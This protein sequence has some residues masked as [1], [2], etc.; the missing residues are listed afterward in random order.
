MSC[1]D[2]PND[3]VLYFVERITFFVLVTLFFRSIK[4]HAPFYSRYKVYYID[5]SWLSE[6]I[7]NHCLPARSTLFEKIDYSSSCLFSKNGTVTRLWIHYHEMQILLKHLEKNLFSYVPEGEL[8]SNNFYMYL[9][10]KL[11]PGVFVGCGGGLWRSLF[12][13]HVLLWKL[14]ALS[15][16]GKVCLILRN[17]VFIDSLKEYLIDKGQEI[18]LAPMGLA[19]NVGRNVCLLLLWALR[20]LVVRAA[21]IFGQRHRNVEGSTEDHKGRLAVN[22]ITHIN[23]SKAGLHSDFAFWQQSNFPDNALLPMVSNVSSAKQKE[24]LA[25]FDECKIK[26]IGFGRY[27]KYFCLANTSALV[28]VAGLRHV[29]SYFLTGRY[30][31]KKWI[32]AERY[33]FGLVKEYWQELFRKHS[34]VTYLTWMKYSEEHCAI[35]DAMHDVGGV[36][37]LYQRSYEGNPTPE[38]RMSA[39][40]MFGFSSHSA[41]VEAASGSQ[42]KLMVITGYLGDHRFPL[43]QQE[44]DEI[45]ARLMSRGCKHIVAFFDENSS[46]D[47][48]WWNG[49]EIPRHQYSF[50]LKKLLDDPEIGLVLKP[51]NPRT[52]R[53]RL[54][55][56][57]ELLGQALQTG[58]CYLY[59][60]GAIQGAV[61]PA[62]AALSADVAVHGSVAAAT[63]G[64][65]SILAGVPTLFVD[66]EGFVMSPFYTMGGGRNV[67]RSWDELWDSLE[68]HFRDRNKNVNYGRF[69]EMLDHFDPFR[70]G[71]AAE[72]MGTFLNWIIEGYRSGL[73]KEI[74]LSNAAQRYC[75][76]WGNDKVVSVNTPMG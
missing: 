9:L 69:P 19:S 15:Y 48:R 74:V 33:R 4:I 41:E 70:D 71:R 37:A 66:D 6:L 25:Q 18:K 21:S 36:L 5:S 13:I 8:D 42:I 67:F 60:Q 45:R 40:V 16:D 53:K 3:K 29:F 23:L 46:L 68:S 64:V 31:E 55:S 56:V 38:T 17:Q 30:A 72:R 32:D 27:S 20:P 24:D 1:L 12:I 52:L 76:I 61:C 62:Q 54:G 28:G 43:V 73:T 10:R 58:R 49:H 65:E 39:D 51:K 47:S 35:A 50:L 34:I 11:L 59:D 14:D 7:I 2:K 44:A 26:A 75:D 63:A 57:G 22:N